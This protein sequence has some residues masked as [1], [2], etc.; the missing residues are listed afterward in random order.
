[1]NLDQ[2]DWKLLQRAFSALDIEIQTRQIEQF[3]QYYAL[4]IEWNGFM[5]L[6][7]ITEFD[8]YTAGFFGKEGQIF[9]YCD[10]KSWIGA[11]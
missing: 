10:R 7:A 4:L 5:N 11:N 6:T 2:Y 8:D 9:K 1:M 3:M